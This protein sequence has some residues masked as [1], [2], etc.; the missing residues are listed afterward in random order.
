[1]R[2]VFRRGIERRGA[3]G[4]RRAVTDACGAIRPASLAEALEPR[5]LL[6]VTPVGPEFHVTLGT[7]GGRDYPAIATDADGDFVVAWRF[8][9]GV[10]ARRYSGA[11]QPKGDAFRVD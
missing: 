4:T 1:M 7:G 3:R 9:S 11:G 6:A 2:G 8:S 10:Y 5:T